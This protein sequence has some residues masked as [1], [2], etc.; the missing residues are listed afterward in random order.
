DSVRVPDAEE[1]NDHLEYARRV[2]DEV[3]YRD[4]AEEPDD[5]VARRHAAEGD[6]DE[7]DSDGSDVD[8]E[9]REAVVDEAP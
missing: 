5:E 9:D 7:R 3:R 1:T 6:A 4:S 2:L 8:R